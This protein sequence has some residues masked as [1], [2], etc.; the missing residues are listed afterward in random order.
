MWTAEEIDSLDRSGA[1]TAL[2]E[3]TGEIVS[4]NP[5]DYARLSTGTWMNDYYN[6]GIRFNDDGSM[7]RFDGNK[8]IYLDPLEAY[9]M[10]YP[11]ADAM[12]RMYE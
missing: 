12:M 5:N 3:Q 2:A 11:E 7:F 6:K 8:I 9:R 10:A 1:Y 4:L